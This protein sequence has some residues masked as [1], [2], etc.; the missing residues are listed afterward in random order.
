MFLAFFCDKKRPTFRPFT[1]HWGTVRSVPQ[2]AGCPAQRWGVSR[3][4]LRVPWRGGSAARLTM[5]TKPHVHPNTCSLETSGASPAVL[6]P[7][8][9][10]ALHVVALGA[11]HSIDGVVVALVLC[12][13]G[14]VAGS[15]LCHSVRRVHHRRGVHSPGG[16]CRPGIECPLDLSSLR[17]HRLPLPITCIAF[18]S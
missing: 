14:R 6:G 5:F 10:A 7:L 16:H 1:A 8:R 11:L 13:H 9:R 12:G 2:A 17:R 18:C 3:S 4:P 15:C